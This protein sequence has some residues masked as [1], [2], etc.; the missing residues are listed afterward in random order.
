[1]LSGC[2]SVTTTFQDGG[3]YDVTLTTAS[4]NGCATSET[5]IDFI[6]VD[7]GPTAAFMPT[8]SSVS[9]FNPVVL[10]LNN[11]TGAVDYVWDFGDSSGTSTEVNPS[12]TYDAVPANYQV[13]LIAYSALGCT[14]TAWFSFVVNEELLF[15]IPN[16]FTPD[17][18]EFNQMFK[19]IFTRGYDPFDFNF[20]I[21]NRWGQL[22]WESHDAE[23]GWDGVSNVS[24]KPVQDGSYVWKIDFK[25]LTSD[26]RVEV[27]GHVNI[28]K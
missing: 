7:D 28:L 4:I 22:I 12:Y 24:K 9:V 18:D 16:T 3:L 8:P 6:N 13:Q 2:D 5:Y 11:S 20:Y 26:E 21:Y 14:D 27:I 15:Y 1:V 17:G 23:Q 10:L 19:A 25:T